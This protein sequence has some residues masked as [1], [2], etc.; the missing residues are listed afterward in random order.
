MEAIPEEGLH[1]FASPLGW[2]LLVQDP[3]DEGTQAD[4]VSLGQV[5]GVRGVRPRARVASIGSE[6]ERSLR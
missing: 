3:D 2:R 4:E 1:P 6:R 5:V